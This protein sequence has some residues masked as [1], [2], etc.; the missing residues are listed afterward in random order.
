MKQKIKQMVKEKTYIKIQLDGI[1]W[2]ADPVHLSLVQ[3]LVFWRPWWQRINREKMM[4]NALKP[5]KK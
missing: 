5:D 3:S 2:P 4:L 1:D